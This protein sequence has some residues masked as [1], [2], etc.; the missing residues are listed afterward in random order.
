MPSLTDPGTPWRPAAL[1]S[2][3]VAWSS[4]VAAPHG[5]VTGLGAVGQSLGC[6]GGIRQPEPVPTR[7]VGADTEPDALCGEGQGG[8]DR[9]ALEGAGHRVV[10]HGRVGVAQHGDLRRR[11]ERDVRQQA[12]WTEDRVL[13]QTFQRTSAASLQSAFHRRE[14]LVDVSL[15]DRPAAAA[16]L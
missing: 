9:I 16:E 15:E 6:L 11:Q 8:S 2:A 14:V 12:L 3:A 4:Q 1:A 5:G 13:E 10:A 7:P